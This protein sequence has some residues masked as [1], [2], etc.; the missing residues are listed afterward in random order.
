MGLHRPGLRLAH[1]DRLHLGEP[2]P[3]SGDSLAGEV[4]FNE[5]TL[6]LDGFDTGIKLNGDWVVTGNG[7]VF[8]TET[9][10]GAILN[11]DKILAALLT[12]GKL[13]G[14]ILDS[15][16]GDDFVSLGSSN[17]GSAITTLVINGKPT[18]GGGPTD[19]PPPGQVIPTPTAA[20]L[21]LVS[22]GWLFGRRRKG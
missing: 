8:V 12:D 6:A 9:F 22:I 1:G 21:G 7:T 17:G 14:T 20:G 13:I 19:P 11:A 5:F 10:T 2:A 16:P 15:D 3:R 18:N 4:N